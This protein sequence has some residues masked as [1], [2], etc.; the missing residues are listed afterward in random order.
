MT[1]LFG[2][3]GACALAAGGGTYGFYAYQDGCPGH[4][5]PLSAAMSASDPAPSP[6]ATGGCC[7]TSRASLLSTSCCAGG[8]GDQAKA[9]PRAATGLDAIVGPAAAFAMK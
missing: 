7:D 3:L 5:C 2:I 1:K 4:S 8:E 6:E 9:P